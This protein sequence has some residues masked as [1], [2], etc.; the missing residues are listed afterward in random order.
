MDK[1]NFKK[2]YGQNFI[3]DES[4]INRIVDSANINKDSLVIEIG[5]GMGAL[6]TKILNKCKQGIIYEIDLELKD[7]LENKLKNYNNYELIFEDFLQADINDKLKKFDYKELLIVA[8][9]PYYITT[10]IIK[11]IIDDNILAD[12][13]VIMIQKEVA[14]RFS[15]KVNTKDYSSLTVFLN[16]YYDI[17][18]L[19]NVSKNMFYP[20]PEVDSSVI[21]MCKRNEK[22]FIKDINK[23]NELV[24]NSF[25][26]KRKNLRNNLKE[27]DLLKIEEILNKYNL[28]LTSRAENIPLNVFIEIANNL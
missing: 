25:K 12:K 6:T 4:L 17:K 5:P 27:Y 1:F 26:Y 24:K 7:Y 9:L 21:L 11:K 2:K 18:K 8:N 28:S 23:F 22:E 3:K 13:I 15:A 16:Y 20:K 19:F 14:D 10:P